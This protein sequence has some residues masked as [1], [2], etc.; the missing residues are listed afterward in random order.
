MGNIGVTMSLFVRYA[1][2]V[3]DEIEAPLYSS[4]ESTLH[5]VYGLN[6]SR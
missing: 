2:S 1:L 3:N 6:L 5:L 4:Q